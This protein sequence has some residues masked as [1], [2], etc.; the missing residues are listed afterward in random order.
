MP[1]PADPLVNRP[2][3]YGYSE[4]DDGFYGGVDDGVD[5]FSYDEGYRPA[6]SDIYEQTEPSEHGSLRKRSYDSRRSRQSLTRTVSQTS[7]ADYGTVLERQT[8]RIPPPPQV[9]PSP[10]DTA[11]R[12]L[13]SSEPPPTVSPSGSRTPTIEAT[14]A[15]QKVPSE[16][17]AAPPTVPSKPSLRNLAQLRSQ[18][19]AS[20]TSPL[21]QSPRADSVTES[22]DSRRPKSKLSALASSRASQ[23]SRSTTSYTESDTASLVTYPELRPSG[24]SYASLKSRAGA[25]SVISA[26]SDESTETAGTGESTIVRRAIQRALAQETP[27]IPPTPPPKSPRTVTLGSAAPVPPAVNQRPASDTVGSTPPP[28]APAPATASSTPPAP[29]PVSASAETKSRPTSKLAQLAQAKAARQGLSMAQMRFESSG[30]MLPKSHTEH[31]TPIANGP[32]ATTA[33]TTSYQSLG[34]LAMPE[35]TK[36]KSR[37]LDVLTAKPSEAKESKLAMKS[38]RS[39][40]PVETDTASEAESSPMPLEIPIFAPKSPRSRAPPSA[41]AAV[42]ADEDTSPYT[43]G[44]PSGAKQ[45]ESSLAREVRVIAEKP[46]R[47]TRKRADIPPPS[48]TASTQSFAFDAPSP[49]DIVFNARRGTSLAAR[50]VSNSTRAP[51]STVSSG[52][53]SSPSTTPLP[54]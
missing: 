53:R 1:L 30:L 15:H 40:K 43:G 14:T 34:S 11:L 13:E 6:L 52:L 42:L 32:T 19:S 18:Q 38:R 46:R 37:T 12:R 29:H 20:P 24:T 3:N 50:S 4:D 17:S 27:S 2:F 31:V 49:D 45:L 48:S 51:L 44:P 25:T 33:I 23:S 28:S 8:L 39:R 10:S 9:R 36:S 22:N 7:T 5:Q 21:P 16:T 26:T 35:R 41:F 47:K 54:H